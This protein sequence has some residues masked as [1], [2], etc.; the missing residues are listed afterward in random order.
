MKKSILLI[1]LLSLVS[2]KNIA[3]LK[4]KNNVTIPINVCLGWYQESKNWTGYMTQGWYVLQPGEII[5][6]PLQFTSD[7][8]HFFYN[9]TT[10]NQFIKMTTGAMF[11]LVDPVNAFKIF[12]ANLPHTKRENSAFI[13]APFKRKDVSFG[14]LQSRSY[15]FS[16]NYYDIVPR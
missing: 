2:I 5:T 15:T 13:W 10:D 12:N 8:D 7:K 3:Q 1:S 9:V 16:I 4:L 6:T 11:M 14:I